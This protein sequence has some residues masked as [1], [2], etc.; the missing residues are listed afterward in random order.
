MRNWQLVDGQGTGVALW[1]G[2]TKLFLRCSWNIWSEL[3]SFVSL[4]AHSPWWLGGS[5]PSC[6]S[7]ECNICTGCDKC[8]CWYSYNASLYIRTK[9]DDLKH[10]ECTASILSR[11]G[12]WLETGFRLVARFIEHL[13]NVTTNIYDSLTELH[14]PKITAATAHRMSSQSSLAVAW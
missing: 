6:P 9:V 1:G 12:A 8:V 11:D 4:T 14:T 5:H 13:Q 3:T 7:T 10:T 2:H